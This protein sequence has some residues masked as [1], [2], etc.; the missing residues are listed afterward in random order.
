MNSKK[1]ARNLIEYMEG[2]S[3]DYMNLTS[4]L[5]IKQGFT[6]VLTINDIINLVK[7]KFP[8]RC[9]TLQPL[10]PNPNIKDFIYD[11][12]NG[13]VSEANLDDIM[14]ENKICLSM[15]CR[16]K[17]EEYMIQKMSHD[18]NLMQQINSI[19]SNQA[20]ELFE[21]Y[22]SISNDHIGLIEEVNMMTPEGIHINSFMYEP[23]IDMAATHLVD[24][25]NRCK[26]VLI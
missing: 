6:D 24:L 21:M 5:H 8:Q 3:A 25:Y 26:T 17:A 14:I 19:T 9:Q 10:N 2:E 16:L 1:F 23:L 18:H 20:R 4:C 13:I 12:A 15:A 22:R 7:N 11:V